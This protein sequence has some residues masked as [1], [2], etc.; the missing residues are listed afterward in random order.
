MET[1]EIASIIIDIDDLIHRYI[2]L[3]QI[4]KSNIIDILMIAIRSFPHKIVTK[5]SRDVFMQDLPSDLKEIF[6]IND[7]IFPTKE[8]DNIIIHNQIVEAIHI[9]NGKV[10][11]TVLLCYGKNSLEIAI[12]FGLG[13]IAIIAAMDSTES[14]ELYKAGADFV[15]TNKQDM[16]HIINHKYLGYISELVA[17][18]RSPSGTGFI[19]DLA[20]DEF[21]DFKI[22]AAGRY[23]SK[24]D[25][26]HKKHPLSLRILDSKY[27][28][29]R[30][31][32]FI[33]LSFRSL[34]KVSCRGSFDY[35]TRIPPKPSDT[36]DRFRSIL[37]LLCC[38]DIPI[39]Q[40]QIRPNILQCNKD[41]QK[42][43]TA[44][45]SLLRRFNVN[46]VFNV[47]GDVSGRTVIIIDDTTTTGATLKE[48]IKV[49][50]DAGCHKVIPLAL[51]F[52]CTSHKDTSLP[53]YFLNCPKCKKEM[54]TLFNRTTG[55]PF[56]TCTDCYGHGI[57]ST[58]TFKEGLS[59]LNKKNRLL[60]PLE[61]ATF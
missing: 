49:L 39:S 27:N 48:G 14:N 59:I 38:K 26:R 29:E 17:F 54:K 3:S 24:A 36:I 45:G 56:W 23:F 33:T 12:N 15:I 34:I 20:N 42:Q 13:T 21:P 8:I 55:E 2:T 28:P 1:E 11:S 43:T 25:P 5:L 22:F 58:Y 40:E 44:G 4:D 61:D 35:I 53:N 51:A 7:F 37:D 32:H 6:N 41:Y 57:R 60:A 31:K 52:T 16:E 19:I 9:L 18:P 10:Y 30:Q 46:G 50:I 47:N